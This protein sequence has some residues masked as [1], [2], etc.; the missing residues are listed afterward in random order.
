[1]LVPGPKAPL[2]VASSQG[3]AWFS[4]HFRNVTCWY[5]RKPC[6][7]KTWHQL[8]VLLNPGHCMISRSQHAAESGCT[9]NIQLEVDVLRATP[10][11][12]GW[13]SQ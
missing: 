5:L 7:G 12:A 6:N 11:R 2:H 13:M 9:Q 8:T 4:K 3:A 10:R 1:M